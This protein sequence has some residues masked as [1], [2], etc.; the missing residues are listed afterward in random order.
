MPEVA[1][2]VWLDEAD[3]RDPALVGA[4][5]A[6]LA[7]AR[8]RGLPVLDGFVVTVDVADPVIRAAEAVLVSTDNSGAARSAVF[9]Q[10][11]PLLLGDLAAFARELGDSLVVRSSSRA[12]A[13]G[14]WAGAFSSY[15]GVGP[16]EAATAVIGCWASIFTPDALKRGEF[17]GT[18]PTQ[19]G[20][21]VLVQPEIQP[22]SGG[23]A[24]RGDGGT[25]TVAGTPGHPTGLAAGWERGHLATITT[26]GEVEADVSSPLGPRLLRKVADLSQATWEKV[27]FNLIEWM[28]G[29][30]GKLY[31]LQAQRSSDPRPEGSSSGPP[32]STERPEPWMR[33]AARMMI[34]YPG[35]VGERFVWP[36]AIGVENLCPAPAEPTVEPTAHLVEKIKRATVSLVSY[37]W[38]GRDQASLVERAWSALRMGDPSP[39]GE[40]ISTHSSVDRRF[41]ASH[42]QNLR[43]LGQALADTGVIPR[44]EWVW[45]HDPDSLDRPPPDEPGPMRRIGVTFWDAWLYGVTT[46]MGETVSGIPAA[47]G[48]GVGR[49]RLINSAREAASFC[50]REVIV[51]SQPIGNLAPLLWNAAGLVVAEGSPGAHL[52]EVAEWLAV[53][54]VCGVDMSRWTGRNQEHSGQSVD[55]IVAV[56]GSL[57]QATVLC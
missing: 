5:A 40:L 53:P 30:D 22:I 55:L 54:A 3:A 39:I 4:K 36:W 12:E 8:A 49:S 35:P 38:S 33:G 7:R 20:M 46:S 11:P 52:F 15:V 26:R 21:G 42:L 16:Q 24:T 14:V 25:V 17:G 29:R 1:R 43:R 45:F 28:E 10:R 51:T 37:R 9:S 6:R 19:I 44:P 27:G 57:G 23:I 56:D 47:R 50:P 34:R 48:W 41:A 31:L 18:A 32:V 13:Q 2:L